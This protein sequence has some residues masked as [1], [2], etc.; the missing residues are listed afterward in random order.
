MASGSNGVWAVDIGSNALKALRLRET[1]EGIEVIG[2]DYIEHGKILSSGELGDE[3][4]QKIIGETLHKFTSR[5][6]FG[7]DEVGISIAG[8]N[9]FARFIKLPPVE[10]KG[11]PKVVQFEAIQQIPF[12]INEVE[13]DWQVMENPDSPDT[14]VG[15]FA[16]KNELIAEIMDHFT[17]ENLRV[18]C[19]QIGPMSLYNYAVYDRDDISDTNQKATVIFDMGAENTTLVVCTK[20]GMWQRSIRIGGNAFTEAIADTFN[21]QFGKSEKLKRKAPM[22]KYMRQIFTAM[23]PVF[24]D[25]GSEVQRSLGFYSSSGPGRESGF[26][27]IIALGGGMKL[28]GLTKYLQQTLGV[29]VV[30]PDS[31]EKLR[32]SPEVSSAKFHENISDFGIVYGLGVQLLGN[33]KIETNLL[34]RKIA[35]A[36]AWS[37]KSRN[38]IIAAGLLLVVAILSFV[39]VNYARSSYKGQESTRRVV[40]SAISKAKKASND[41]Q[42][43]RSKE[44]PLKEAIDKEMALFKFRDV[45]PKLNQAIVACLPNSETNPEQA[46]LYE[47]FETGDVERIRDVPRED[48]K[49]VF[50]TGVS[51]N[52]SESI[53]STNFPTISRRSRGGRRSSLLRRGST[54]MGMGMMDP[55]MMQMMMRGGPGMDPRMM[56]PGMDPRMMGP[57][58]PGMMGGGRMMG[59]RPTVSKDGEEE[60][61]D[62][63]GFIVVIE[64]YSPY[65]NIEELMDPDGVGDDKSKWGL[66]TRLERLSEFIPGSEFELYGKGKIK[67]FEVRKDAVD[68]LSE[69]M[70]SGIGV[71]KVVK[72][73]SDESGTTGTG[74]NSALRT[75][76]RS[77]DYVAEEDVLFDPMTNE[78]ISRIFDI[79]TEVD[80]ASDPELS[81]SQVGKKKLD[82]FGKEIFI[83]RDYWFRI[84]AKFLWKGSPDAKAASQSTG[85]RRKRGGK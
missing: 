11:I 5:N 56:G 49:Q 20:Y 46:E 39:S 32:V 35:R 37:R 64:G 77:Q 57:M 43:E 72:R 13:W 4:K 41:L 19:V 8:H 62:G 22:S 6:E 23:K 53:A 70:P 44:K 18:T 14:E 80:I 75:L 28:Q 66:I 61:K 40:S 33:S 79:V 63:P 29:P 69:E 26:S 21:L 58:N 24:T 59:R 76:R 67:H 16:I 36:M 84:K 78:E 38:F 42:K 31:F 81:D 60:E 47:A 30:K 12:D 27:R 25:L 73:I 82:D 48:R 1:E 15:I 55:M 52:Y 10:Q 7:K 17:R 85:G 34:P 71:E 74:V 68:V 65:K 45:V 50:I 9:S 2:F 3:A 51:I 83:E 54:G